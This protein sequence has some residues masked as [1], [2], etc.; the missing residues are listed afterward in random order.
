MLI[1]IIIGK[2]GV[3]MKDKDNIFS[4]FFKGVYSVF[5]FVILLPFNI[6]KYAN[7]FVYYGV[8]DSGK[9]LCGCFFLSIGMDFVRVRYDCLLPFSK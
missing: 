4:K 5:L 9:Y 7:L 6:I 1:W 2:A 3:N 8:F